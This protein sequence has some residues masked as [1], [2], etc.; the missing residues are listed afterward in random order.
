MFPAPYLILR[1]CR[2]LKTHCTGDRY[3]VDKSVHYMPY[4]VESTPTSKIKFKS[5]LLQIHL[6]KIKSELFST[7]IIIFDLQEAE[8]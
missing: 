1:G 4:K 7:K 8:V 3:N 2:M 5:E 6:E